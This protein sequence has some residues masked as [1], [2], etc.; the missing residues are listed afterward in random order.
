[1]LAYDS[2][3][4]SNIDIEASVA[5]EVDRGGQLARAG[6]PVLERLAQDLGGL[7]VSIVLTDADDNVLGSVRGDEHATCRPTEVA[8]VTAPIEDPRRDTPVGAVGIKGASADVGALILPYAQLAA[9]TI[10]ERVL[11]SAVVADRALVEYFLRARRRARGPVVAVNGN[12]VLVNAAAA[13][14]VEAADHLY[15]WDWVSIRLERN[16][17]SAHDLHLRTRAVSARCEPVLVRGDVVG[18][19]VYLDELEPAA[20][21]GPRTRVRGSRPPKWGWSSLRSSE[22]GIAE[23][24]AEGLTNREVGARLFVSPHTVDFHLRQI[25]RKLSITSRIELTRLVIEHAS[26]SPIGVAS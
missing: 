13:R 19:L 10:A 20:T 8:Y 5:S 4:K 16:D 22:L 18:A 25:F 21:T 1:M 15:L 23:L 12:E 26:P 6:L 9:R 11:D 7:A 17:G 3:G 2:D 14:L 24:V